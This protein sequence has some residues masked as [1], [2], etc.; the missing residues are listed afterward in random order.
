MMLTLELK[1]MKQLGFV[2]IDAITLK[3]KCEESLAN[4]SQFRKDRVHELVE[5]ELKIRNRLRSLLFLRPYTYLEVEKYLFE[6]L[7]RDKISGDFEK[8]SLW[9]IE[10]MLCDDEGIALKLLK[11]ISHSDRV[12]ISIEAL[13]AIDFRFPVSKV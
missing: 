11:T 12:F 13:N 8:N 7:Q 5:K 9:D 4:I 10:N 1:N 6:E 2:E 3:Q